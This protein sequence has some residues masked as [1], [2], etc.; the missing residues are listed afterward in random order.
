M[1]KRIAHQRYVASIV[2]LAGLSSAGCT[3]G[4]MFHMKKLAPWHQRQW[5]QDREL[6]PTFSMRMKELEL[7]R[8]QLPGM[9]PEDQERWSTILER[10]ATN[11]TSPEMRAQ[12]AR[13]LALVKNDASLRALD[14]ASTDKVEKVRLAVCDAWG[15][16]KDDR[17]RDMLLSLVKTDESDDVRQAALAALGNFNDTDV[18]EALVESLDHKNPA[19]Q[20]QAVASLSKITGRNYGGDFESWKRYVNGEDVPEPEP[21]TFTARVIESIPGLR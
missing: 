19:I 7:L 1:L 16:R 21:T 14:A 12:A 20:Q 8:S 3:D 10:I 17:A 6:G 9:P 5:R 2:M 13:T 11:D 4:P 15:I 18:R